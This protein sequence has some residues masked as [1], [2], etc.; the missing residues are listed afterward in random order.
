MHATGG[1]DVWSKR[2]VRIEH[3]DGLMPDL[4]VRAKELGVI[5]VQNPTH[6]TLRDL[7]V[8]RYGLERSEQMQSLR[9]LLEAGIPVAFGSDGY[10]NPY[11]NIM[12]A[13]V[14]PG[15]PG[16][17]VTREQAVTA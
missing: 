3:G 6:F 2:R 13:S 16:E 1:K 10:F 4:V 14:Y 9:S 15:K 17:A 7:V 8:K 5:V 11:L 12:F